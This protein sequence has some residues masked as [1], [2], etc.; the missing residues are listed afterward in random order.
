MALFKFDDN[1]VFINTLESYPEACFYIVSG[2][3]Y[4][5]NQAHLDSHHSQWH[6]IRGVIPK[7]GEAPLYH[8]EKGF[9]SVYEKNIHRP[10]GSILY[11]IDE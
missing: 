9:I 1:D 10:S 5:D 3:V 7:H 4:I 11:P 6:D 8:V 2:T